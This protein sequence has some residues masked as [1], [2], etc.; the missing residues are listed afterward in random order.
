MSGRDGAQPPGPYGPP[1]QC[2]WPNGWTPCWLPGHWIPT[3]FGL[4]KWVDGQWSAYSY[5]DRS[6]GYMLI[7]VRGVML[8][9]VRRGGVRDIYGYYRSVEYMPD[10]SE[11]YMADRSEGY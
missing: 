6:E 8:I 10:R 1:W 2:E 5:A 3:A 4:W 11:G 7:G 9:G